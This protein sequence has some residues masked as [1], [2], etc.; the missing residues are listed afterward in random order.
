M[1]LVGKDRKVD[2]GGTGAW[3]RDLT[4]LL[5][6]ALGGQS[7]V[8]FTH[9]RGKPELGSAQVYRGDRVSSGWGF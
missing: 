3:A 1:R 6:R 2:L 7:A 9:P 4:R 5:S 8:E